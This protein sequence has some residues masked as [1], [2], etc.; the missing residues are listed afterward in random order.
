MVGI[1]EKPIGRS[2]GGDY[3]DFVFQKK[4]REHPVSPIPHKE[5]ARW[6]E[7]ETRFEYVCLD[8]S[9]FF[10]KDPSHLFNLGN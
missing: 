2:L 10:A 1:I 7:E 6:K 5:T 9:Y 4:G 3:H 8:I